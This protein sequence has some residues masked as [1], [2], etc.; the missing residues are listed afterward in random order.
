MA[1]DDESLGPAQKKHEDYVPVVFAHSKEEA[2][3]YGEL[4]NDHDVPAIIGDENDF[5]VSGEGKSTRLKGM[6]HGVPVLVPEAMLDEA[7]QIIATQ[8][9][10]DDF[11]AEEQED[12]HEDE[13]GF[14]FS[15]LDPDYDEEEEE[16]LGEDDDLLD[17]DEDN[18]S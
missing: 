1:V 6:T 5:E 14:G 8:E 15:E 10:L 4:L 12:E 7:G 11:D 16:P 2:E 9:E 3:A 17:K 18:E 13:E